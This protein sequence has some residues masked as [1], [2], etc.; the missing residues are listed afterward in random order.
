M[1]GFILIALEGSPPVEPD[2][3][4]AAEQLGSGFQT[5]MLGIDMQFLPVRK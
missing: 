3:T 1:S 4:R 5:G 2:G